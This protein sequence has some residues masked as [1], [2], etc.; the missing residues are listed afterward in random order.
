MAEPPVAPNGRSTAQEYGVP[1]TGA[2]LKSSILASSYPSARSRSREYD[3]PSFRTA[4]PSPQYGASRNL[5]EYSDQSYE[6]YARNYLELLNQKWNMGTMH[7]NYGKIWKPRPY[8][9]GLGR[10][11]LRKVAEGT[12]ESANQNYVASWV[13][14]YGD[15]TKKERLQLTPHDSRRASGATTWFNKGTPSSFVMRPSTS[16]FV[17]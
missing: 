10:K 5:D 16:N 2:A 17:K 8:I 13:V 3:A 14:S 1:E 9:N 7:Y 4:M 12:P 11:K 6:S 15:V